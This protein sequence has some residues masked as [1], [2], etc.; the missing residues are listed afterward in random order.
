[1]KKIGKII[2]A[3]L[4]LIFLAVAGLW[5]FT[6][7]DQFQYSTEASNLLQANDKKAAEA[8]IKEGLL[9]YPDSKI[10]KFDLF[11]LYMRTNQWDAVEDYYN[12]AGGVDDHTVGDIATHFFEVKDWSKAYKYYLESGR[13]SVFEAFDKKQCA[14][15]SIEQYRNAAAAALNMGDTNSIKE[16][17]R[18]M[19]NLATTAECADVK[20][21]A[22]YMVEVKG[23]LPKEKQ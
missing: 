5:L 1:M 21:T 22:E 12:T 4:L 2:L 11:E 3:I 16:A 14:S 13:G 18:L 7:K 8:K 15:V 6:P 10:L 23:W 20:T 17:Y 19:S 9:K